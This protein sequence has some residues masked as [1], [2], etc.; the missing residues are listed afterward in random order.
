[1]KRSAMETKGMY[2]GE[3]CVRARCLEVWTL[4]TEWK[5]WPRT[6][7]WRQRLRAEGAA[8]AC[9]NLRRRHRPR[10]R[11]VAGSK[12]DSKWVNVARLWWSGPNGYRESEP[13]RRLFVDHKPT[14]SY[15]SSQRLDIVQN[16]SLVP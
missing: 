15:L 16:P 13:W 4:P 5:T 6:E 9:Y 8:R 10:L 14:H 7:H 2:S 11:T 3:G 12:A 1:M